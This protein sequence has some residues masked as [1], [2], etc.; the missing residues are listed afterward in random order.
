MTNA[1]VST[2]DDN[3]IDLFYE[4]FNS[5]RKYKALDSYQICL[6]STNLSNEYKED[7]KSK[8]VLIVESEWKYNFSKRS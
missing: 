4:L 3:R 7:L 1:I 8:N 5:I 2:S 6:L